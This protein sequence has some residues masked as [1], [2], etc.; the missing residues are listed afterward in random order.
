MPRIKALADTYRQFD[1]SQMIK[2]WQARANV[3]QKDMADCLG[4]TQQMYS[5]KLLNVDFTI[6]D[7]QRMVKPLQVSNKEILWLITGREE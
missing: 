2:G 6:K 4:I 3:T 7:I 1:M 5:R